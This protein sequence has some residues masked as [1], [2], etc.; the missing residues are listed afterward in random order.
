MPRKSSDQ[1]ADDLH[2]V[3]AE[4][5]PSMV[6]DHVTEQ[7]K[8]QVPEQVRDQVPGTIQLSSVKA[9]FTFLGSIVDIKQK[10]LLWFWA[11][12]LRVLWLRFFFSVNLIASSSSKSSST[13]GDV[14]EGGGVSLNVTLSGSSSFLSGS[15]CEGLRGFDSNEEEVVIKVDEVSLVDGVFDGAFGGEGE[16]DVVMGE[17]VVVTSSSLE[18]L[19]NSCL[20]GIMVSLIFLEGLEE[21]A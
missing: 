20:G 9:S 2:D 19:T 5:L 11:C 8:K 7:V 6:K 15:G 1:L 17:G 14:L 21:E 10:K 3:M 13:Q 12:D 16:E 18:M 4:T